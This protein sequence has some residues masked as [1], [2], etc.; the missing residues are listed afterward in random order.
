[1]GIKHFFSWFK[2]NKQLKQT[3]MN[4][5]PETIDH[6]LIDMNGVIHEAAQFVF[7]YGK[8]QSK[9]NLPQYLKS[10]ITPPTNEDLY[11]KIK[12]RVNEIL[13]ALNPRKSVFLAI[14]GVAPKSKQNQQ[15]QRRFRAAAERDGTG[16]TFDSNCITAGT[17]FMKDLSN[18]LINVREWIDVQKNVDVTMSSESIPGEGEHKLITWINNYGVDAEGQR[19]CLS[20]VYCVV[21]LDADLI[22]L[23]MLANKENIYIMREGDRWTDYIDISLTRKLIPISADDLIV[24][25]CFIGNDFLPP[26]PTLEIKESSPEIGA[27]DY[28]IQ[29]YSVHPKTKLI[30]RRNGFLN[31]TQ[32]R[33]ILKEISFREQ[34]IMEARRTDSSRFENP[35]W[36][37]D[38]EKYR[39]QYHKT[40]LHF[41][42]PVQIVRDY[43][44]TVQW[45]Y[46]YYS[47]HLTSEP[48]WDWYY[49]Y[50]YS[51]HANAFE[52]H[53]PLNVRRFSFTTSAPSHPHEQLLRVIPPK[54]KDLIPEY[55]HEHYDSLIN[56][57]SNIFKIDKTGKREEWE[58][59]TI[60]DFVDPQDIT[61]KET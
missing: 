61:Y 21:G 52:Q 43:M 26:I 44:K 2:H 20:D 55:L 28:F 27:L 11:S 9:I 47:K 1:M 4:S 41:A 8:H 40:K 32:I 58:A 10:R 12:E 48:S 59:V 45:V 16:L 13:A 37:G 53:I 17:S 35:M 24:L 6:V 7:K 18:S 34:A 57:S 36:T 3:I 54:N 25:S 60:V 39:E 23:C 14:D 42:D 22:L 31:M 49:P 51:L 38:I 15:R 56:R 5:V 46:L 19:N 29:Y 30:D 50:N 33:Q